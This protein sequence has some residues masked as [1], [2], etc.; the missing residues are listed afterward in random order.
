MAISC[1]LR[2]IPCLSVAVKLGIESVIFRLKHFITLE[3]LILF[4][5]GLV[6]MKVEDPRYVGGSWVPE[7]KE[8]LCSR[9]CSILNPEVLG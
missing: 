6:H 2:Q 8:I 3:L 1:I 5:L 4:N 9:T 7:V